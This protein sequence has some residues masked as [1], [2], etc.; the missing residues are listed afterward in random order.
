MR[1]VDF[2]VTGSPEANTIKVAGAWR[3]WRLFV[4]RTREYVASPVEGEEGAWELVK[5]IVLRARSRKNKIAMRLAQ[6][7]D[8]LDGTEEDVLKEEI[9]AKILK[10]IRPALRR[11]RQ[12]GIPDDVK[13]GFDEDEF[14]E[15]DLPEN[16]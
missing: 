15:A 7:R 16:I 6:V 5:F 10:Q 11:I 13:E 12:D 14:D 1:R 9:Y 3:Y 8:V 2:R 4:G